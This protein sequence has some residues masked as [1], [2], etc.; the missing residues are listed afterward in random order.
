VSEDRE[1][2]IT[3]VFDAPRELVFQ[4]W[5]DPKHVMSWWGPRGFTM[6]SWT[7]DLRPGGAWRGCIRS[8]EGLDYW[9]H[10]VYREIVLPARLVFTF[11]WDDEHGQ[12]TTE[13]LVTVTFADEGGKTKLTFH[14]APFDTVEA[15][16]S[17]NDGWSESF[18]R[19]A[20]YL[21]KAR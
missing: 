8:P 7:M 13:T 3:R 4:A 5:S 2:S 19:L 1:L 12:P 15:R 10:G 20:A 18:E 17:H 14:Q 9:S 16:D 11:A 21:A 6:T